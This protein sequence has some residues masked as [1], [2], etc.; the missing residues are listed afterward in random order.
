LIALTVPPTMRK[1]TATAMTIQRSVLV[2]L[3]TFPRT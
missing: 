1:M 2:T 3:P